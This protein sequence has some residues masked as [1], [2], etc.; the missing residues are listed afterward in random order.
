[1]ARAAHPKRPYSIPAFKKLFPKTRR[2]NFR[3]TKRRILQE[4]Q[5]N[6]RNKAIRP[7]YL[8]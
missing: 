4:L 6:F 5:T 2:K 1:M 8:P 3:N 7:K